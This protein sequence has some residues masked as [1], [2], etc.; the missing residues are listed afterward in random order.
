MKQAGQ[1][2]SSRRFLVFVIFAALLAIPIVILLRNLGSSRT[3]GGEDEFGKLTNTGRNLYDRGDTNGSIAALEKALNLN[4]ANATAQLNLANAYLK[5][6][7]PDKALLHAQ[8]ALKLD[9]KSAA[10]H[11]IAGSAYLRLGDAKSAAQS[12]EQSKAIDRTVNAVSFQLGRAYQM[13]G[14]NEQAAEQFREVIKFEPEHSAAHYTLS[15]VLRLLGN[16]DEASQE[17]A[18]HQELMKGKEGRITDPSQFERSTYTQIRVPF[19][20]EYP[21]PKGTTVAFVDATTMALPGGQYQGPVAVLD[22]QHN[23][24]Y[25]LFAREQNSYR[26]LVNSNGVFQA[27]GDPAPINPDSTYVVALSGDLNNDKTED[28]MILGDKGS[29]AFRVTTNGT[30]SDVSRF[31]QVAKLSATNGLLADLDYSAKLGLAVIE[32]TN[33]SVR[34]LRNLGGG[35]SSRTYIGPPYFSEYTTNVGIPLDIKGARQLLVEDWNNDDLLDLIITRDNQPP[36]LLS[37]ERGGPFALTNA[38]SNWPIAK[39]AVSGDMD[40]DLHLDFV[41]ATESEIVVLFQHSTNAPAKISFPPAAVDRLLLVDY[42]SDGWLDIMGFGD[43]LRVWRNQGKATFHERTAELGLGNFRPGRVIALWPADLDGDCDRDLLLTLGDNSVRLLRNDGGNA[44]QMLKLHLSGEKS[45][46]SS[47][48]ARFE[49]AAGGLRLSRRVHHLPIEIGIG[50]H[51]EVD[52]IK[53]FWDVE[54]TLGELKVDCKNVVL[55]AESFLPVGSCPYL[56]AWDGNGFRFVTDLLGA[57]PLGLPISDNRYIEADPEEYVWIGNDKTFPRKGDSY[58]VQ[59]TEELREVLYLDEAKLVV[60]DHPP[61]TEVHTTGKLLPGKPFPPHELVTLGNPHRLMRA[62]NH[63]GLDVT[64]TLVEADGNVASPARKRASQLV[65]LAEPHSVTLDFGGLQKNRPLV[66]A[67]TGWLRFGGGTAN[68][69]ASHHPDLPFPFPILEAETAPGTWTRVDVQVGAPAGK[70][71]RIIVELT[72]KLPEGAGR[73]RLSTAFEIHWDRI[74]LLEKVNNAETVVSVIEPS[75]ADLHWRGYSAFKNLPWHQPL[76]PDYN[77]VHANPHW[78]LTPSGWCTRYGDIGELIRSRDGALALLN[79]G[80]ELTLS[81]PEPSPKSENRLRDLFFYS[82][83]WDKDADF[84]CKLGAQVGPLPWEGMDDQR[85]G[86]QPRPALPADAL[87]D[88]YNTRWVGPFTG[89]GPYRLS[90]N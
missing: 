38:P 72:D 55:M 74:A 85:Y 34:F 64:A 25:S 54:V 11:F 41:F 22:I 27:S 70:T 75:K 2:G 48:G 6:N 77:R 88:R 80:D 35:D 46:A 18:A 67:M 32:P 15:Q 5:A 81:F 86:E 4:P 12:L 83:G 9:A 37:K 31:A 89:S 73:L 51:N 29:H 10:A 28:V 78:A 71:K 62:I 17:L 26:L 24:N 1:S 65:G 44:N 66:L 63:E 76:T 7:I 58:V 20:P 45:N 52:A 43:G 56:Y 14:Q 79:G 42:D 90:R 13:L 39:A 84:H 33:R 21:D 68:I 61:G 60:V 19:Q 8:Q 36:L 69:S 49:V 82:V 40:G 16:P 57:A 47:I 3:S 30:V 87:M 50:K 23:G 53:V 59:V